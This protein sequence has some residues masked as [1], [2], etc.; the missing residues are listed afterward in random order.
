M[1]FSRSSLVGLLLCVSAVNADPVWRTTYSN[2]YP[3][4]SRTRLEEA[5]GARVYFIDDHPATDAPKTPWR[6]PGIVLHGSYGNDDSDDKYILSRE[7]NNPRLRYHEW[8]ERISH[9][10]PE[11][12]DIGDKW[13]EYLFLNKVSPELAY[14]N[15]LNLL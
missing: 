14:F 5:L 8:N 7:G 1:T 6:A 2:K 3:D 4:I 12:Q 15:T 11:V 10:M 13:D 9:I